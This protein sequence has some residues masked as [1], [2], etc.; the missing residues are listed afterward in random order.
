[1][2]RTRSYLLLDRAIIAQLGTFAAAMVTGLLVLP[3]HGAPTDSLHFVYAVV[4][5]VVAP[6]ARY[7][8]R[9]AQA[10]RMGRWQLVAGVV[11]LGVVLRLFM[12]GR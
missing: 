4:G 12:T 10:Q 11:A 1:M 5:L 8:T 3:I 9:N 7:A 2:G 6:T